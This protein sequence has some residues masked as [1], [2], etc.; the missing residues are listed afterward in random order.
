MVD[1]S[2]R[3]TAELLTEATNYAVVQ[4]PG[5]R[6]PG[7]VFQGDS[8][9]SLCHALRAALAEQDAADLRGELEAIV[10]GLDQVLQDYLD[11]LAERGQSSPTTYRPPS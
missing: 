10:T 4:L 5:R 8:L 11:V 6:F 2:N 7:V 3:S 1:P 9:G